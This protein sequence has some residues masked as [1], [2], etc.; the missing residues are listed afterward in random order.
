[1]TQPSNN[2]RETL[3]HCDEQK[4]V[5][6]ITEKMKNILHST[7]VK[8]KGL[9]QNKI[10]SETAS[11]ATIDLVDLSIYSPTDLLSDPIVIISSDSPSDPTPVPAK[12]EYNET[13]I[14]TI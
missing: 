5:L 12:V 2:D 8:I 7:P 3:V 6:T 9:T 1:M 13:L 4:N 11:T 10:I 14:K